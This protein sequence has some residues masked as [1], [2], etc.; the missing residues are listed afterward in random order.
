VRDIPS[1]QDGHNNIINL[2]ALNYPI[3]LNFSYIVTRTGGF[4]QQKYGSNNL[5]ED[6]SGRCHLR[7]RDKSQLILALTLGNTYAFLFLLL[8]ASIIF[9]YLK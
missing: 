6:F 4:L 9:C 8:C 3:E 7:E 5:F 2:V 1:N